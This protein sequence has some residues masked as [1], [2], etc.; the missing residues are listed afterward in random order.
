MSGINT[1]ARLSGKKDPNER[2]VVE[3]VI[4]IGFFS[5]IHFDKL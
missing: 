2:L 5:E 3:A 1:L 4:R